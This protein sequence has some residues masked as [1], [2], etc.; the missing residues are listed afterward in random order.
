M[1]YI[2]DIANPSNDDPYFPQYRHKDWYIGSSWAS[3][4]ASFNEFHGRNQES[5]SEAIAAYEGVALFGSAVENAV[6]LAGSRYSSNKESDNDLKVMGAI[7]R[8]VYQS[9]R[10][11]MATELHATQRY[12]HVWNSTEHVNSY[13]PQ[14]NKPVVGMM[15]ETM[16]SFQ[17]WFDGGDMASIGIQLLPFTP[18][19]EARDD[20]VWAA[21]TFVAFKQ[22]CMSD[23]DFCVKNG[24]SVMLS[25]LE[26]TI[27]QYQEALDDA[28]LIPER[29]FESEGGCG[30]S[31]T[32]LIWYIATRPNVQNISSPTTDKYHH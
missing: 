9:G 16:A 30:H 14:Y 17:T 10:L 22:S 6:S 23:H 4:L 26:A 19:A 12:W 20:P 24:W 28:M 31:R 18:V 2:R 15:Y 29:V 27:G 3:G 21:E 25:G 32:N 8:E 5:S 11:L 13:P 1:L 7:G